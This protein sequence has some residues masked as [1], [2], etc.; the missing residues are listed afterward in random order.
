[1]GSVS[2]PCRRRLP[3]YPRVLA[4]WV[5]LTRRRS[6][7]PEVRSHLLRGRA[8]ASFR[9]VSPWQRMGGVGHA[10]D[11]R[12]LHLPGDGSERNSTECVR[13]GHHNHPVGARAVGADH[14]GS[15]QP[16]G[17]GR[18]PVLLWRDSH[19]LPGSHA[20]G[21]LRSILPP[22]LSLSPSG[23][24][25][26]IPTTPG[27]FTFVLTATQTISSTI[28]TATTGSLTITISPMPVPA[29][30]SGSPNPQGEVG[31]LYSSGVSVGG[32]PTPTLLVASGS[33]PPGLTL[34]QKRRALRY[35]HAGRDLHL[36]AAGNKLRQWHQA[37]G[38]GHLPD[39][40]LGLRSANDHRGPR[41]HGAGREQLLLHRYLDRRQS[42]ASR[43]DH[44]VPGT[45]AGTDHRPERHDLGPPD[46]GGDFPVLRAG[47]EHEPVGQ[48]RSHHAGP[49]SPFRL[50]EPT[51]SPR[52]HRRTER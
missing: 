30:L 7:S 49:P 36:H 41:S 14:H 42:G 28:T 1:M 19:R 11:E 29:S 43:F 3:G 17:N 47:Q 21:H 12:H 22:G 5:L 52:V 20:S 32:T 25:S 35:S 8:A 45:T 10:N 24:I 31:L 27:R 23:A 16:D 18:R 40:D 4:R 39:H 33:L 26:G 2:A 13:V 34:T 37:D 46:H 38:N 15:S 50:R 44:L 51:P 6:R 9:P 48:Q